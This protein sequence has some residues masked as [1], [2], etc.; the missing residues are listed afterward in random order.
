MRPLMVFNTP[1]S[2]KRLISAMA[3]S[4]SIV[5]FYFNTQAIGTYKCCFA[6]YN[7]PARGYA[8]DTK[9]LTPTLLPPR[10]PTFR[11]INTLGFT[12]L[13]LPNQLY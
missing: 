9:F 7:P 1:T 10:T 3:Y 11:D 5:S 8:F 2:P 13:I 12:Q 6:V 4:G